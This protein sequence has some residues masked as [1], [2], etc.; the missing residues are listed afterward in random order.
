MMSYFLKL[1]GSSTKGELSMAL[2]VNQKPI[3]SALFSSSIC[4]SRIYAL[5]T[6]PNGSPLEKS[7][8][9]L[10]IAT[11]SLKKSEEEVHA[12]REELK[13]TKEELSARIASLEAL[14]NASF[15]SRTPPPCT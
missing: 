3:M 10:H 6:F 8:N 13:A 15:S 9:E 12:T 7:E 2:V 14:I 11:A 1:L 4:K 5:R